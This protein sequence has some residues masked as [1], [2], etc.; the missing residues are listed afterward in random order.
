MS[1]K[2]TSMKGKQIDFNAI[3]E[4]HGAT[5][6]LGNARMNARGDI[7]GRGGAVVKTKE[8]VVRDYYENNPKAVSV[9]SVSLKDLAD[10]VMVMTPAE[11]VASLE[12]QAKEAPKP[13]RKIK[14]ED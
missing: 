9:T 8:T 3:R 5:I 11:V 13:K 12:A 2:V 1:K 4:A 10:E 7:I 6:A 14:D